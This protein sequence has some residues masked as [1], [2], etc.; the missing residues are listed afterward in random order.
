MRRASQA[1]RLN[2]RLHQ[3]CLTMRILLCD[4]VGEAGLVGEALKEALESMAGAALGLGDGRGKSSLVVLA[5]GSA[6]GAATASKVVVDAAA[7][8]EEAAPVTRAG[9]QVRVHIREHDCVGRRV[10]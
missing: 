3:Y 8:V 1:A 10:R 5:E 6:A 2:L 4:G 9:D 7:G